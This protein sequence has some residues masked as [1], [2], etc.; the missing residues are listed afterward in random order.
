M[1]AM[2][3]LEFVVTNRAFVE[4]AATQGFEIDAV[5]A[6]LARDI[7]RELGKLVETDAAL[8]AHHRRHITHRVVADWLAHFFDYRSAEEWLRTLPEWTARVRQ[9]LTGISARNTPCPWR[10]QANGILYYFDGDKLT[11]VAKLKPKPKPKA[12]R[13]R[14]SD[15]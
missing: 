14:V 4:L 3:D 11:H 10:V 13:R 2:P 6:E 8:I 12:K 5:K 15:H 1:T 7:E 9:A